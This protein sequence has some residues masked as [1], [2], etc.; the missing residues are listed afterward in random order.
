MFCDSSFSLPLSKLSP[1]RGRACWRIQSCQTLQ[2]LD[3]REEMD[4]KKSVWKILL[5][6]S[7]A[8]IHAANIISFFSQAQWTSIPRAAKACHK[9]I[10]CSC[11]VECHGR[12]RRQD[13]HAQTCASVHATVIEKI[14]E[15]GLLDLF[16]K[17]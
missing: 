16:V 6:S 17:D 10:A 9:I 7:S 1:F 15:V 3:G 5:L 11:Q 13:C 14:I 4:C 12:C 2:T 8:I